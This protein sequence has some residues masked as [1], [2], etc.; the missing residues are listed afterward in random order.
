V[1]VCVCKIVG[2]DHLLSDEDVIQVV[3]RGGLS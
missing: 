3:K 1:C 2:K